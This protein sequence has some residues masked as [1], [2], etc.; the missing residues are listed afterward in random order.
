MDIREFISGMEIVAPPGLAEE[1][2]TARI[3][4]II[5]GNKDIRRVAC[6]LD[7]SPGVVKE[8]VRQQADM[9]VVH[10]TPIFH[11]VTAVRGPLVSLLRSVLAS[12]MNIFVMHTNFDHAPRGVND[13]LAELLGLTNTTP[14]TLGLVGD[15]QLVP[16]QIGKIL[17]SPLRIWGDLHSTRSLAVVG[18]SGFDIGLIQEAERLGADAFLSAEAKHSVIRESPLPLIEATHYALEAPAMQLLSSRMGWHYIDDPPKM[19][20]SQ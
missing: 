16:D 8:A 6:A 18:G 2:D 11:P 9:L 19:I 13:S 7:A 17:H 5:E 14:M 15:C 1:F 20:A 10:H 12:G 3:G 4:L